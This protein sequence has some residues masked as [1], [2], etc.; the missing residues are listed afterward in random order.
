M[1][2]GVA[3]ILRW[4]LVIFGVLLIL[5]IIILIFTKPS[6]K[7]TN[8]G[9]TST[10][11]QADAP[12]NINDY[13][14]TGTMRY[15]QVGNVTAPENHYMV[16]ININNT[17]R[18]VEVYNGYAT[19]PTSTKSYT[20]NQASYDAF[21]GALQ[22]AG[23]TNTKTADKGVAFNTFCTM[24]IRYNYQIVTGEQ[25][26]LNTWNSSCNAKSGTFAGSTGQAQQLFINQ[27]PDYN[28]VTSNVR[29]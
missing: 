8:T 25:M 14:T 22:G 5:A 7:N 19:P 9:S 21:I 18:T 29:L 16:V 11:G 1:D 27:I 20:N 3:R 6:T 24:G 23:F 17:S 13:K 4:V 12:L 2:S 10:T 26:P 15:V 28:T